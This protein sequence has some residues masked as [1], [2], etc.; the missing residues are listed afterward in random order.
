MKILQKI[1]DSE[2]NFKLE[3]VCWD[4]GFTVA[5]K[6]NGPYGD[7]GW[8]IEE[9]AIYG[10]ENAINRLVELICYHYPDSI[11]VKNLKGGIK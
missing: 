4:G 8:K 11:F 5:I 9:G 10:I 2:I 1:Y 3:S 6:P 7:S